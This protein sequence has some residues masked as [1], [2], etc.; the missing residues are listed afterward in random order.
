MGDVDGFVRV[1]EEG[2]VP[3]LLCANFSEFDERCGK[4]GTFW[5]QFG[6]KSHC[7]GLACHCGPSLSA[8]IL[9]AFQLLGNEGF[10]ESKL[11]MCR[12]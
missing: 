9:G 10:R 5:R 6:M 7:L 8:S 12:G 2:R 4:I 3:G 11:P 1:R